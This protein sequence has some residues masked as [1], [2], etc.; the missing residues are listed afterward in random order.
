MGL[1]SVDSLAE[2]VEE[3][4]AN[5]GSAASAE[6]L[7]L[8]AALATR[9]KK[10]N[11]GGKSLTQANALV[12]LSVIDSR[13]AIMMTLGRRLGYPESAVLQHEALV[14][15]LYE[16]E[17]FLG[18]EAKGDLAKMIRDIAVRCEPSLSDDD[19]DVF[20]EGDL[21]SQ[22]FYEMAMAHVESHPGPEDEGD[23]QP[24]DDEEEEEPEEL[25]NEPVR[26]YV[27]GFL[28]QSLITMVE[29]EQLDIQPPWQRTDVWSL[30]KKRELIKSLIL[31][32]P[33]PSIIL[34]SRSRRMSIIDGKQRLLSIVQFVKNKYKLPKFE[35]APGNPLHACRGAYY[36]KD[37]KPSLPPD[38]RRDFELRE[39][40]ALLFE[41]VPE[42]RLRNIFHL[43]NVAGTKLNAA[44]I[45]NA[46][47][48]ANPI[49]GVC[50]VLAGE[51]NGQVDLGIGG[52]EAQE[53][54]AQN[55]RA[56]YPGASRRYQGVD[57]L[58][59]YLGYS[60]AVKAE[61]GK[62]FTRPSTSAAINA[63][64]DHASPKENPREVGVEFIRVFEAAKRFFDSIPDD[65]LAFYS[66]TEDGKRKFSKLAATTYMV[67]ARFLLYLIDTA[68][69]T[70]AE[71]R[72]GARR[73]YLPV[74]DKQQSA[75]I[76]DF[77]ARVL[78]ALREAVG[79][80]PSD[81]VDD[82]WAEFF[83]N[84]EFCLLPQEAREA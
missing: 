51:G 65:Q 30:K 38:V 72:A 83:R 9:Q 63:Y 48:Q 78:S 22:F 14:G 41:D 25:V 76:W 4:V 59:R 68:V 33:L 20:L 46:V 18:N 61:P 64:F 52:L 60:R 24:E 82:G 19:L 74:P 79:L 2:R 35:V 21:P 42:S 11:A 5:V 62:P 56:T 45:R 27:K 54:F 37:G 58:A 29:K 77:Q 50:Y 44:E 39:I 13:V 53:A 3:K 28:V 15:H 36:D 80:K 55:L 47:Y 12:A 84:M 75:T 49:H 70:E 17:R 81:R 32:I 40:P 43:Y 16:D 34:H 66:R 69:I 71:A 67:A 1:E 6:L 26:A 57:F 7:A 8:K 73:A 23:F 10:G 31:G